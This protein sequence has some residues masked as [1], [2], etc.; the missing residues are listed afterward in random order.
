MS[1]LEIL[2][3]WQSVVLP[4]LIGIWIGGLPAAVVWR[5]GRRNGAVA[6]NVVAALMGLAIVPITSLLFVFFAWVGGGADQWSTWLSFAAI[7]AAVLWLV[8]LVGAGTG[9]AFMFALIVSWILSLSTFSLCF[10][11]SIVFA[12]FFISWPVWI[13]AVIGRD[14]LRACLPEGY[15]SQLCFDGPLYRKI[16]TGPGHAPK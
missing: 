4:L 11:A 2:T 8:L 12:A 3:A 5:I 6:A 16:E 1:P 15:F 7:D 9:M 10:A 14:I 13:V